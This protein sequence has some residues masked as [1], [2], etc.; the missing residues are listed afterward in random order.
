MGSEWRRG[1]GV[2]VRF[3]GRRSRVLVRGPRPFVVRRVRFAFVGRSWLRGWSSLAA[4]VF[5]SPLS[6][7]A[8]HVMS[9][10]GLHV[11]WVVLVGVVGRRRPWW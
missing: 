7:S 8:R 6:S 2:V 9:Y 5:A 4:G 10:G 11:S 1:E 3:L